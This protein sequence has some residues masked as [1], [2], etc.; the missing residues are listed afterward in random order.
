MD[1]IHPDNPFSLKI[2][3]TELY[4]NPL[5]DQ[6]LSIFLNSIDGKDFL[7]LVIGEYQSGKTSFLSKFTSQI[8]YDVKPFRFK[9]RKRDDPASNDNYYP[10]FLYKTEHNQVII[11]DDAHNLNKQELSIILKNTWNNNTKTRKV[12]LFCEPQIHTTISSLLKEM[13]K[14]TSVNKLYMPSFDKEQTES[15]IKHY[16]G[17]ANFSG[18]FPFSEKII[19]NIH[20][21]TK[22]LPG[23]INQEAYKY[24]SDKNSSALNLKQS[25]FNLSVII[26]ITTIILFIIGGFDLFK[27]TGFIPKLNSNVILSESS[28]KTIATKNKPLINNDQIKKTDTIAKTNIAEPIR[29]VEVRTEMPSQ[30]QISKPEPVI[31]PQITEPTSTDKIKKEEKTK[32]VSSPSLFHDKWIMAQEP[33]EYTI[34]VMAANAKDAIDRFLKLN[35]NTENEFAYYKMYSNGRVW[36]KLI[37]GRYKT[38]EK[39]RTACYSLSDELKT[40]GPWPR[41]FASIHNDINKFIKTNKTD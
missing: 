10:A 2:R 22:G 20:K 21:K 13:P 9:I 39:A 15:Y 27:E 23:K 6:L 18:K 4:S 38:L 7:I 19:N 32:T 17:I 26:A 8:E 5:I 14:K 29:M 40:F 24:F 35:I 3:L 33:Q 41:R 11:L 37:F 12:V 1:K 28:Q 16:L 30:K 36:Y 25:K 34:Q 31:K